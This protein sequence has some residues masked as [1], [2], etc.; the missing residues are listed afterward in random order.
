MTEMTP[1]DIMAELLDSDPFD[2]E[3]LA[4]VTHTVLAESTCDLHEWTT[5]AE[6][7]RV[8]HESQGQ[9]CGFTSRCNDCHADHSV[10]CLNCQ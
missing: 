4:T 2:P 9:T 1:N 10:T 6:C 8:M 3:Y 5:C 7:G